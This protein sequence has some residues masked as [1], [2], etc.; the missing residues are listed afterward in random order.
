MV[1]IWTVIELLL[2]VSS[3]LTESVL[4]DAVFTL[5][6]LPPDPKALPL[7]LPTVSM[8]I[9]EEEEAPDEAEMEVP[10]APREWGG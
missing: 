5:A 7:P 4:P 3:G 1:S 10:D 9:P 6:S 8:A 2:P